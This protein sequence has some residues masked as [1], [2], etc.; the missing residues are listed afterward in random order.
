[1]NQEEL[2]Q[3][4]LTQ[5]EVRQTL[6]PPPMNQEVLTQHEHVNDY[7]EDDENDVDLHD[8]NVG[9]LDAYYVQENIDQSI[10]YSRCYAFNLDDDSPDEEVDED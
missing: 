5:Q 1:M 2:S 3:P 7:Y 10:S 4:I 6:N 8:N 9:D